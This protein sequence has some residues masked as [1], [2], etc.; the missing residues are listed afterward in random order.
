MPDFS[1][2]SLCL[3]D[4]MPSILHSAIG[5]TLFILTNQSNLSRKGRTETHS[6]MMHKNIT[7][8]LVNTQRF[9]DKPHRDDNTLAK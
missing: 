7:P 9:Q 2:V 6:H 3:L 5:H 1:R 8:T 4:V